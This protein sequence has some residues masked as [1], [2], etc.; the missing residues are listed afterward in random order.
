MP[1]PRSRFYL[2]GVDGFPLQ[3]PQANRRQAGIPWEGRGG[4]GGVGRSIQT[5][6]AASPR[7][8]RRQ[9]RTPDV[10]DEDDP[11]VMQLRWSSGRVR[12]PELFQMREFRSA[13]PARVKSQIA[14]RDPQ[15]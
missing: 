14:S 11:G 4:G 3:V 2:A 8:Q 10:I 6:F 9:G 12:L 7:R 15:A 1:P 5:G 13:A